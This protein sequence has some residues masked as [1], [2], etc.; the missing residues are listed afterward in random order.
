LYKAFD[1]ATKADGTLIK[2]VNITDFMR[3]WV[4]QP[5]FPVL[6]VD[7]NMKTGLMKLKQVKKN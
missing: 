1:I 7:V 5:G 2:G 4:D 6:N 3:V